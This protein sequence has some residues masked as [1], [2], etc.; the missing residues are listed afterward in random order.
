MKQL[1]PSGKSFF[2]AL[3]IVLLKNFDTIR[4]WKPNR[5]AKTTV[6]Q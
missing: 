2:N 6:P 5:I 3:D 1:F 4:K